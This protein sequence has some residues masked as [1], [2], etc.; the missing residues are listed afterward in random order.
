MDG[1]DTEDETTLDGTA[2]TEPSRVAGTMRT[3]V[4]PVKREPVEKD[5][6]WRKVHARMFRHQ[7][8]DAQVYLMIQAMVG[9]AQA[10]AYGVRIVRPAP[11]VLTPE[12]EAVAAAE[13]AAQVN[14]HGA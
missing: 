9:A 7:R 14:G 1:T 10:K 11:C 3:P 8:D 12:G 2:G 6:L 4:L 5:A 13:A